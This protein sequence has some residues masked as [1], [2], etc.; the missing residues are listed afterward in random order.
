[1]GN[2]PAMDSLLKIAGVESAETT[3]AGLIRVR[4]TEGASPAEAIVQAAVQN[5]W[6][7]RHIAPDQTSLEEV[8]VQLTYQESASS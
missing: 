7:L 5:G 1:M 3:P 4:H 2:A 8:F 6:R